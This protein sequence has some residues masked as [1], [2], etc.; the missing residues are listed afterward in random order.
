[1]YICMLILYS[2]FSDIEA[3]ERVPECLRGRRSVAPSPRR[4]VA[5][6]L[7][8]DRYASTAMQIN[9]NKAIVYRE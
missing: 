3:S 4:S 1:M 5:P 8:R 9:E 2:E 6:S 7:R